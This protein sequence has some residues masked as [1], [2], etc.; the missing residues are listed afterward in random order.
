MTPILLL[1]LLAA[2]GM[3]P[4]DAR[5]GRAATPSPTT[6]GLVV[7]A[8]R[9]DRGIPGADITIIP[10]DAP[11][12][13]DPR[14]RRLLAE[15]TEARLRTDREGH[16]ELPLLP[17]GDWIL[18]VVAT[19]YAPAEHR[20]TADDSGR[21]ERPIVIALD[22]LPMEL[23]PVVVT[24]TPLRSEVSYQVARSFDRE[25]LD[26]RSAGSIGE[27][28]DGEPGLAMRSM[29]SAPSRP[30]I[31]GFD[32]DRVVVLSNGERMGDL[33]ETAADHAISLDPLA[34][35][36]VE[37][38]RGPAGLLYGSSALGG[39]VNLITSDLPTDW[40]PGTTGHVSA[41]G[42]SVNRSGAAHG[43][44]THGADRWG[45]TGRMSIREAGDLR[46]PEARLPGTGLSSFDGQT[47]F[48][49]RSDG[50]EGALSISAQ[51]R[52]YG[53][54]E[55]LDDPLEEVEIRTR[56][57]SLQGVVRRNVAGGGDTNDIELRFNAARFGQ[58][59]AG[60]ALAP[61]GGVLTEDIGLEFDQWSVNGTLTL[62]HRAVG[63]LDPGALGASFRG[64]ALEVG[65]LEAFT[66][67]SRETTLGVF[68]FQ[69]LPL[70][71]ALRLQFGARTET[72]WSRTLPNDD[73]PDTDVRRTSSALSGSVALNFRPAE[74]WEA[75]IQAA[76]AHRSPTLEE[77]HA[78]GPHLG[79]GAYEVGDPD[80]REE[81]GHGADLF[82][83]RT[84]HRTSLELAAFVTR[85]SDFIAFQPTGEV[86]PGSGL[87]IF[88]YEPSLARMH[89]GEATLAVRMAR[90]L[91]ARL[92]A[93]YVRG[94]Q[95]NAER[96]PLPSIPP[97]RARLG[98][99]YEDDRWWGG[100]T[101]RAVSRQ[102]RVAPEEDPT[103]GYALIDAAVARSLGD[104]GQH[105]LT[106][107]IEN[108]TNALYR[109]HLSRVEE[110]GFPMPGRNVSLVYRWSF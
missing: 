79:A 96:T 65:G 26:R 10:A 77:L 97:L 34:L 36:S 88:R 40:E 102:H 28:L 19:G 109:D 8:T 7:D 72:R 24:A 16:F 23:A 35:R 60:M 100:F 49:F 95:L 47:G 38:V 2:P 46:T 81:I 91:T 20:F 89:G 4:P 90:G 50:L 76:R 106:L 74:G 104:S 3:A 17:E 63:P 27:M 87:P 11:G 22:P 70:S 82:V 62:R 1:C 86:D 107:R 84:G 94:V 33:S 43:G 55:A 48:G 101:G 12:V 108:L 14:V 99:E 51:E 13:A 75:G 5:L 56:H 64:R 54:P 68:A 73:F 66:P 78:D 6:T 25:A 29:G 37:V 31:R 67:G 85:I 18:G 52:S 44:V 21:P 53:I 71:D 30:V 41:H 9:P 92:G 59:E 42:A 98:V 58:K 32:G 110:R 57:Q 103:G 80:L 105:R 45:I 83:R 69:E 15:S 39:V 93:D 61:S